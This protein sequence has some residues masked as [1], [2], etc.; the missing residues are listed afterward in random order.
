MSIYNSIGV[1]R[2]S[3]YDLDEFHIY[4]LSVAYLGPEWNF[5]QFSLKNVIYKGKIAFFENNL[6]FWIVW[7]EVSLTTLA[8]YHS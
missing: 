2:K 7:L 6:S 5:V 1:L 8:F 4:I 3:V